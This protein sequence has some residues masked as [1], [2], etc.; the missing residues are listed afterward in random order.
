MFK[1]GLSSEV[2]MLGVVFVEILRQWVDSSKRRN[3][4]ENLTLLIIVSTLLSNIRFSASLRRLEESTQCHDQSVVRMMTK[5]KNSQLYTLVLWILDYGHH[6]DEM[7]DWSSDRL[8]NLSFT[9]P[10]AGKYK[11]H[12]STRLKKSTEKIGSKSPNKTKIRLQMFEIPKY[13]SNLS[14]LNFQLDLLG[15]C[16]TYLEVMVLWTSH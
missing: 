6:F 5:T 3:N 13:S 16:S 12:E 14:L 7:T 2:G 8:W 10:K 11:A 15:I 1:C 4:A 9:I